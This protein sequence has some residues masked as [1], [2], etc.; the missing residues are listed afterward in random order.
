MLLVAQKHRPSAA[1]NLK[2]YGVSEN[3]ERERGRDSY[4]ERSWSPSFASSRMPAAV[5]RQTHSTP[6]YSCAPQVADARSRRCCG[7]R[8][9]LPIPA[10]QPSVTSP[11]IR[12]SVRPLHIAFAWLPAPGAIAL[13]SCPR[14]PLRP[15][16]DVRVLDTY[17]VLTKRGSRASVREAV[18][19]PWPR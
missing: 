19:K 10:S 1:K 3:S 12:A 6:G 18:A 7:E 17:Q 2:G 9:A 8:S 13:V 16:P 11:S 14:S 15:A 5:S 4:H